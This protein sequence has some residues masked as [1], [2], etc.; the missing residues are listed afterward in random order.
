MKKRIIAVVLAVVMLVGLLATGAG[1]ATYVV[2]KGDNPYFVTHE[3]GITSE[4]SLSRS[5][6]TSTI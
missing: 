4:E 5:T 6:S 1:A 2:G 3:S